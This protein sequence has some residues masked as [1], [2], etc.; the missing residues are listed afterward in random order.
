MVYNLKETS[1]FSSTITHVFKFTLLLSQCKENLE[2]NFMRQ[3]YSYHQ[4]EQNCEKKT[5][6][7]MV[8]F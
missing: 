3:T 1:V 5:E 4:N 6:F 2:R 7:I 8:I